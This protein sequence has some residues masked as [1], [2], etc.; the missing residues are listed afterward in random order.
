MPIYGG[1]MNWIYWYLKR[2]FR[3][4]NI[5]DG[6][7]SQYGQDTFVHSILN[8]QTNGLFMDIGAHDGITGSNT[9]FFEQIG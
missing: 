5:P 2:R 1:I 8:H 4:Y 7:Y 6:K 9:R 3:A